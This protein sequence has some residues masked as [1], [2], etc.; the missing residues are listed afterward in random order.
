MFSDPVF[1]EAEPASSFFCQRQKHRPRA[2]CDPAHKEVKLLIPEESA[3]IDSTILA[4]FIAAAGE[5]ALN[6]EGRIRRLDQ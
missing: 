4:S 1:E 5:I 2:H 3:E 6:V